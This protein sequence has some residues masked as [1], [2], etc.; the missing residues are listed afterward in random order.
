MSTKEITISGK[1]FTV[2][3]PFAEG[4]VLTPGE[5]KALNQVRHEN[6][7]NNTAKA[8]KAAIEAGADEAAITEIVTNYDSTYIFTLASIG[9][10]KSVDPLDREILKLAREAIKQSLA[11]TGRKMKD[12]D[13]EKLALAIETVSANPE[14]IKIAKGNLKRQAELAS[15]AGADIGV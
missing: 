11:K 9:G 12:A 6:I 4:H 5:A 2:G 1:P 7:R 3:V 15:A 14:V 8:V 13:P 10:R